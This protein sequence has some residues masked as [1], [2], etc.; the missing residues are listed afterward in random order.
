M[1]EAKMPNCPKCRSNRDVRPTKLYPERGSHV[2]HKGDCDWFTPKQNEISQEAAR[3]LL[4]S[5]K[6]LIE[7]GK[8]DLSN[9]KY[10][11]YFDSARNAIA[12]AEGR[13]V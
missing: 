11:G 7:I 5:L 13:S 9:P 2:C 1:S 10:D 8:R 12:K 3:E 6:D 4:G